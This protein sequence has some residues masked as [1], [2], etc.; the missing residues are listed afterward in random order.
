MPRTTY[1]YGLRCLT[2]AADVTCWGLTAPT[3]C[4]NNNTHTID[5]STVTVLDFVTEG[6]GS[7]FISGKSYDGSH[8]YYTC[9]GT[10]FD[11]PAADPGTVVVHEKRFDY[12][13]V[14]FGMTI[15]ASPYHVQDEVSII[16]NPDTPVGG[17]TA[18]VGLGVTALPV[19]STV[20]QYVIPGFHV[21][22]VDMATG[23]REDMQ[24]VLDEATSAGTITVSA[25]T[26]YAFPAASTVVL[27]N[28]YLV[29]DC[30]LT[31]EHYR[32]EAGYGSL[33]GKLLPAGT[34]MRMLYTNSNGVAK[35]VHYNLEMTY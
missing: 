2:E 5:A 21:A 29:Q 23:A 24:V 31:N 11:V 19:S 13:V 28:V 10:R 3:C 18:D 9:I 26:T 4:P 22:L 27:L 33:A 35:T 17:L 16:M 14:I 12:N 7:Q 25:A 6:S 34:V 1:K 8:G 20:L 30:V 32:M 15:P